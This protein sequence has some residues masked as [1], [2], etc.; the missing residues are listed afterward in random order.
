MLLLDAPLHS[1]RKTYFFRY[2]LQSRLNRPRM[3]ELGFPHKVAL[4]PLTHASIIF[5]N[6]SLEPRIS[7][8]II[9]ISKAFGTRTKNR[10]FFDV[11]ANVGLYT[12]TVRSTS[13]NLKVLGFEPDPFNYELL[14]LTLKNAK[15]KNL[16]FSNLALSDSLGTASFDQDLITSATGSI[17]DSNEVWI[18]R[19]LGCKSR[20]IEIKTSKI[21]LF[22]EDGKI[23]F[24]I[25]IDVEGHEKKV[26]TGSVNT[27]INHRPIIIVESFPPR[28]L[29]VIDYLF[30]LGYSIQDADRAGA[31]SSKTQ[32][33]FAWHPQGPLEN[34][35]VEAIVSNE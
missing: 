16:F 32:N 18:E 20:K 3:F 14:E 1:L 11:G 31:V 22:N 27:I 4:R 28:Q 26:L 8:L 17:S 34:Q 15:L 10:W 23:P 35:K 29:D 30:E 2:L 25:K 13:Q 12:W 19:Y 5:K 9:K 24:L 21:D 7:R 33:L 6:R